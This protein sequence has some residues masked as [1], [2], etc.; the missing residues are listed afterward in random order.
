MTV[1]AVS[2]CYSECITTV[3]HRGFN[4]ITTPLTSLSK[5]AGKSY[6]LE[7]QQLL[8]L[9]FCNVGCQRWHC[10]LWNMT[11]FLPLL[12]WPEWPPPQP[13]QGAQDIIG[14]RISHIYL[15]EFSVSSM[16]FSRVSGG[17]QFT[18]HS[19]VASYENVNISKPNLS[20]NVCPSQIIGCIKIQT[21]IQKKRTA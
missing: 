6:W 10:V 4:M 7:E 11:S 19:L 20:G 16:S 12:W 15:F 5:A 8:L 21:V 9:R 3:V 1:G 17:L 2:E 18:A 13:H 14:W